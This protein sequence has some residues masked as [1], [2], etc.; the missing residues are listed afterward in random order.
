ME[1]VINAVKAILGL[2]IVQVFLLLM[3]FITVVVIKYNVE[4]KEQKDKE[5]EKVADIR[6]AYCLG[7]E[8]GRKTHNHDWFTTNKIYIVYGTRLVD[9]DNYEWRMYN[10]PNNKPGIITMSGYKFYVM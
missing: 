9:D 8:S 7:P 4:P 3:I 10:I 5:I 1:G 6:L 2:E